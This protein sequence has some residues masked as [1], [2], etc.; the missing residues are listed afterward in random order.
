MYRDGLRGLC[1]NM[2]TIA[3]FRLCTL[4]DKELLEKIDH[5]VDRMYTTGEIP[6]RHIPA[7]PDND[8]DLLIGELILRYVDLQRSCLENCSIVEH[9][10]KHMSSSIKLNSE[11]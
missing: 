7:E 9:D 11:D 1:S 6:T 10:I 5:H 4:N 3:T 2:N 8:F